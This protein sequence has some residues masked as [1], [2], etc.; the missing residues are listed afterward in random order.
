MPAESQQQRA[1]R[2][3]PRRTGRRLLAR[4]PHFLCPLNT[5]TGRFTGA[6]PRPC[7]PPGGRS[8][9]KAGMTPRS[10]SPSTHL[11][12]PLTLLA[13]KYASV[14]LWSKSIS[15][16][17]PH[18]HPESRRG[19][20]SP[21]LSCR[22]CWRPGKWPEAQETRWET[23][24]GWRPLTYFELGTRRLRSAAFVGR[25]E[26]RGSRSRCPVAAAAARA[27]PSLRAARAPGL[28]P[29][30]APRAPSARRL[31]RRG[32]GLEGGEPDPALDAIPP[33]QGG[34]GGRGGGG[35]AR[36]QGGR[37]PAGEG[38]LSPAS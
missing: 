23:P 6:E 36:G 33:R 14:C 5:P 20:L 4:G 26:A 2:G 17:P 1:S 27:A 29:L 31:P 32:F 37:R 8:G 7:P 13:P 35:A 22:S 38:A 9:P 28:S 34:D 16:A 19:S 15:K 11:G 30:P 10:R 25:G 3:A 24:G 21:T 18:P 12:G